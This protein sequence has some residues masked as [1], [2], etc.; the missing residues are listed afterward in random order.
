M[1]PRKG[2]GPGAH[3]VGG[4]GATAHR[5]YRGQQR[6][7]CCKAGPGTPG[8]AGS[9]HPQTPF[10][11]LTFF[12]TLSLSGAW[13]NK[14]SNAS[15]SGES[16][17][18]DRGAHRTCSQL[19][20]FPSSPHSPHTGV[21]WHEPATKATRLATSGDV[22]G[23]MGCAANSKSGTGLSLTLGDLLYECACIYICA[24]ANPLS[25]WGESHSKVGGWL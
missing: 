21:N 18:T 25:G 20:P 1:S 22:F 11:V 2:E 24:Q 15:R 17:R 7:P 5:C 16:R 12:T 23:N 8:S 3:P 9:L 4:G 10:P 13:S 19:A 6:L 14:V